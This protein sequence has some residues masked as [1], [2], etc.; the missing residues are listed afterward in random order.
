MCTIVTLVS[1]ICISFVGYSVFTPVSKCQHYFAKF[2]AELLHTYMCSNIIC[3]IYGF[4]GGLLCD[5]TEASTG[6]DGR[7]AGRTFPGHRI[8]KRATGRKTEPEILGVS[9]R[10]SPSSESLSWLTI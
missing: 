4:C 5:A 2:D 9:K 7:T 8:C 10:W 1:R 3:T 6:A